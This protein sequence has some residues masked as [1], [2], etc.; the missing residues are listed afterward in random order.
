MVTPP[1]LNMIRPNSLK[2]AYFSMQIGFDVSISI[3]AHELLPKQ[4]GLFF[5]TSP[6]PLCSCAFNLVMVAGSISD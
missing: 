1:T 3:S 4:R 2:F 6:V 5:K